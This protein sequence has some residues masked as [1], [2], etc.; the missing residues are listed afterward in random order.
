MAFVAVTMLPVYAQQ[1]GAVRGTVFDEDFDVP[2]AEVRVQIVEAQLSA[3]SD[4]D[5]TFVIE[6]VPPGEYTIIFAKSGYE[7]RIITNTIV[8]P[9]RLADLGIVQIATETYELP[10]MIVTGDDP[11][12]DSEIAVLT[13][14]QEATGVI[15]GP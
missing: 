6:N 1:A 2:V 4:P 9:G 12:A 11:L 7:R 14:R 3:T 10:P 8:T 13:L 15:D 5:G